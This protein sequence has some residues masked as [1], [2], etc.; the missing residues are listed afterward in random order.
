MLKAPWMSIGSDIV[1]SKS[2]SDALKRG[3]LNW[4]VIPENIRLSSGGGDLDGW[5]ATRRSDVSGPAGVL[6]V[7]GNRYAI[8]QNADLFSL[9]DVLAGE[10]GAQFETMGSFWGGAKVWM[11]MRL[12]QNFKVGGTDAVEK[13]LLVSGS[14]DGSGSVSVCLTS[15]RV[16]CQNTLAMALNTGRHLW[17]FKHT[18]NAAQQLKVVRTA[19]KEEKETSIRWNEWANG[20]AARKVSPKYVEAF[21]T[22]LLNPNKKEETTTR[23][24]NSK[25]ALLALFCGG[26]EGALD[27]AMK[28][29]AWGLLNSV[30]QWT[31][32]DR[33]TRVAA[34]RNENE[35]RLDSIWYGSGA[36]MKANAVA[37]LEETL[38]YSQVDSPLDLLTVREP[39]AQERIQMAVRTANAGKSVLDDVAEPGTIDVPKQKRSRAKAK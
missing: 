26:Q 16:V 11:L 20:L 22:A 21:Y 10:G 18:R 36:N 25:E 39:T 3:G 2:V 31:D 32:H 30:T 7:V 19:L 5:I 13:Y 23:M 12:P 27:P 17:R 33:S 35:A 24:D 34:G 28:G 9:T 1:G 37:L 15:V 38:Q 29:T 14:H 4:E 8:I 6:G